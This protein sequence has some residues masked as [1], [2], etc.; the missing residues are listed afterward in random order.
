MDRQGASRQVFEVFRSVYVRDQRYSR[1][2]LDPWGDH[3]YQFELDDAQLR[4]A[5][6][7]L[8]YKSVLVHRGAD[9]F[10]LTAE[11]A[12]ACV[13]PGLFDELLG[14]SRKATGVTVHGLE[15]EERS[16]RH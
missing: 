9:R 16:E 14:S 11:G 3:R 10:Q 5:L 8:D 4:S 12:D 13:R 1:W 15:A 6:S 7:L 2:T